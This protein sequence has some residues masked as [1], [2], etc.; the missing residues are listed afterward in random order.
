VARVLEAFD[1]TVGVEVVPVDD[2]RRALWEK[3]L[4]IAPV[5][6]VG[7]VCRQAVGAWRGVSETRSLLLS[8][9]QEVAALARARG[10]ALADDCVAR[11]LA[12]VDGLPADASASMQRDV[13]EGRPSELESQVGAVV[14]LGREAGVETPACAFLYA[15]LRPAELRARGGAA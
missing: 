8:A 13:V 6:G 15:A 5:S 12:Y 2:I 1:G 9:L 3:F 14:R 7:A 4:F 11:T 10:V